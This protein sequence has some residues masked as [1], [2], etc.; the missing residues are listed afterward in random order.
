MKY[1][2]RW[3]LKIAGWK[4][5]KTAPDLDQSVICVAPHT[6]NWDFALCKLF[7]WSMGMQ[8]SFLMKKEWLL[9][10]ISYLL[11]AMGGIP[12]VRTKNNSMTEKIAAEFSKHK[13]FHIA[14]APEGTRKYVKEWRKGFYYIALKANV[15]IQLAYVDFAKKEM[16]ITEIFYPTGDVDADI[17][18]IRAFY[19]DKKGKFPHKFHNN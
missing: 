1:I 18:K 15:P 4:C 8:A 17:Q 6:S 2:S 12:V 14:I 7:A 16:G 5:V 19:A 13:R 11:Q 10:P 9:F 3:I